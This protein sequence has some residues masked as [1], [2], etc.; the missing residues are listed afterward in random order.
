MYTF[1]KNIIYDSI[2]QIPGLCF[3]GC[4]APFFWW[5]KGRVQDPE[6]AGKELLFKIRDRRGHFL[7]YL[8][9]GS[10]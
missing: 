6:L 10:G 3:G 4:I 8:M 7:A 9:I 2:A 1:L 5:I